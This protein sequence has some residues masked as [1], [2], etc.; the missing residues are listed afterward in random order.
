MCAQLDLEVIRKQ[1]GKKR[2]PSSF[3][4]F[5]SEEVHYKNH[6]KENKL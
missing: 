1:S 2:I 5:W 3:H 6:P 4:G